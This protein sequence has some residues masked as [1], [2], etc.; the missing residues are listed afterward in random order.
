[1]EFLN[2]IWMAISTPNESIISFISIFFLYFVEAP[3]TFALISNIFNIKYTNKQKY[4]YIIVTASIAL[5]SML[6]IK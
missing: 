4:F 5:L 3:L 2:N 1:M 6:I